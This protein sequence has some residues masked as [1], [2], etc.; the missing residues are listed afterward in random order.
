MKGLCLFGFSF[1][2]VFCAACVAGAAEVSF[3]SNPVWLSV[4]KTTEGVSVQAST[5]VT[6]QGDE[7]ISGTVTFY[8]DGKALGTSDFSLPAGVGGV[9]VALSFVPEKGTHAVSAKITKAAAGNEALTVTGEAKAGEKLVVEPDNDRDQISD[10]VDADDDNDGVSDADEK[11]AGTDPLK[12]EVAA[13]TAPAVAGASTTA[14]G[15]VDQATEAAKSASSAV[16]AKTEDFRLSAG[17]YFDTK[18]AEAEAAKKAKQEAAKPEDG[19][20]LD[21]ILVAEPKSL[22]EQVKDTSGILERVKIQAYKALSFVF[23]SFYAFYIILVLLVLWILRKIWKR[24]SL[25]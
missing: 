23:N 17:K 5:V 25:D 8:S 13:E 18:L 24:Y 14:N 3:V 16:L 19:T 20:D 11:K 9:I 1:G 6:K 22:T 2:V 15:I 21:E 12:K 7:A 4:A 10:A